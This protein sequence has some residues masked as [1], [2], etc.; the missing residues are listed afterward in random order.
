VRIILVSADFGREITT[1][2]LRLNRF[3]GMDI[4]LCPTRPH[5]VDARVPGAAGTAEL[6]KG[7]LRQA[8]IDA[9][10]AETGARHLVR[11]SPIL[12]RVGWGSYILSG[13]G[14]L[15]DA[16]RPVDQRRSVGQGQAHAAISYLNCRSARDHAVGAPLVC[17]D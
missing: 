11:R 6:S 1:T 4:T 10:Y 12:R 2:V 5:G 17:K 15:P 9:G 7:Q 8:L 16:D 13:S 14:R 3:D